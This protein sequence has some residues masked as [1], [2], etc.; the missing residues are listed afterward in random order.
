MLTKKLELSRTGV[1]GQKGTVVTKKDIDEIVETYAPKSAAVTIWPHALADWAPALGTV[2][3]LWSGPS[4]SRPGE[5]GLFGV[6]TLNDL[7]QSAYE[8]GQYP[9]WSIGAPRRAEDGKRYLHHLKMCGSEPGAVKGLRELGIPDAIKLSDCPEAD[10]FP[11]PDN[12]TMHL[13]DEAGDAGAQPHKEDSMDPIEEAI[14]AM[15]D[16]AKKKTAAAAYAALKAKSAEGAKPG[17]DPALT[18]EVGRLKDQLKRLAEK[19]PDEAIEL[20][21]RPADPRLASLMA[22]LRKSKKDALL[23]A[24]EGKIPK[25]LE[26][27]LIAL[28]DNLPIADIIELSDGKESQSGEKE[29]A[30]DVFRKILEALPEQVVRGEIMLSDPSD[31]AAKK[32]ASL[33][34]LTA[35]A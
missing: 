8:K 12:Q 21:D 32:G 24:A 1:H 33:G 18:A 16:E 25:G 5:T 7:M 2:D 22:G 11:N 20:S 14:A 17:A 9:T 27:E 13:N 15:T 31:P 3:K 4:E 35:Y 23:K 29:S 28:A 6:V 34:G 10:M 26:K 19:Y 30:F